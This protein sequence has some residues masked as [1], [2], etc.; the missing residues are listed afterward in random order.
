MVYYIMILFTCF[1]LYTQNDHCSFLIILGLYTG[2]PTI[3][4]IFVV[5]LSGGLRISILVS[6]IISEK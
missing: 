4:G 3:V 6:Y 5:S 2:L 1:F